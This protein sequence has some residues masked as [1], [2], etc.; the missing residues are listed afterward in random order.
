MTKP[1]K[2]AAPAAQ[3]DSTV[4]TPE[5]IISLDKETLEQALGAM[6]A[7][8]PECRLHIMDK[9]LTVIAVDTANVAM[10]A[11]TMTADA[12]HT[13][14]MERDVIGLDIARLSLGLKIMEGDRVDIIRLGGGKFLLTD[15]V[16]RFEYTATDQ[17]TI[18]KDPSPPDIPLPGKIILNNEQFASAIA[19]GKLIGEKAVLTLQANLP[20]GE[21]DRLNVFVEGTTDNLNRPIFAMKDGDESAAPRGSWRSLFSLD[22][23]SDISKVFKGAKGSP[24]AVRLE[25]GTDKPVKMTCTL[26]PGVTVTYLAAPRIEAD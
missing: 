20:P 17:S 6:R 26:A 22:Y 1:K 10:I 12:F 23:L 19:A 2:E 15:G 18:R 13:F 21:E 24:A 16:T 4:T 7:L 11:L 9:A 14:T 5:G 25:L 3:Q 8:L